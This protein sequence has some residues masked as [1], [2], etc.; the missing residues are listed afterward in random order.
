MKQIIAIIQPFLLKKV[1]EGLYDLQHFPGITV[2]DARGQGRGRGKG[3]KFKITEDG[4]EY[5]TKLRIEIFCSD[6]QADEI[7]AVIQKASH[8]GRKGDGIIAISNLDRVVR[9]RTGEDK[10]DAV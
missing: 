6:F 3:G 4:I 2:S 10:D 1:M 8:T 5:H 7:T 9:I